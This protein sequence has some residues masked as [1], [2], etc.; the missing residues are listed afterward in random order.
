MFKITWSIGKNFLMKTRT[1]GICVLF[2]FS[3]S[4][5]DVFWTSPVHSVY[6]LCPGGTFSSNM[7]H[8]DWIHCDCLDISAV[9][10]FNSRIWWWWIVS[11]VFSTVGSRLVF[12]LPG[13]T[14][15][16]RKSSTHCEQNLNL[17]RTWVQALLN[18]VV[19]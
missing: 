4:V 1:E 11:V 3:L 14:P 9:Y 16:H 18:E 2:K 17:R 7:S 6:I 13:S 10:Y 5:P 19:Q 15:Q 12:F 8:S